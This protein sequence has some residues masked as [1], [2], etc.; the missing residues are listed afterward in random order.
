[1]AS[2][3]VSIFGGSGFLGRQIVKSLAV[4][5]V[6]IRVAVR[7]PERAS[8][9]KRMGR[10]GQIGLV[11]A[12]VWEE[13]SVARAV[14][15]STWVINTVGHYVEKSGATFDAIHG[16]GAHNVARQA[17]N[18]GV[19]R[20]IHI[21]GVGADPE[22]GSTYVRARGLGEDLVKG[23]F[24]DVTILRPSVLFGPDDSFFNTLAGL[25]RQTP[26]LP[27]FGMGRT[28]LQP[29]FVG[30]VSE[31]CVNVLADPST[32]GKVYEL[33]GPGIYTYKALV[34]LVLEHVGKRRALVPVPFFVWDALAALLSVLANPPVTRDQVKLMKS[35]NVV[36]EAALTLED[37]GIDPT[38]VE[39]VLPTYIDGS[40]TTTA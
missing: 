9:L 27:L 39:E 30:D 25:A 15:K 38:P 28:K 36:G 8:F 35:D 11:R 12:N 37:L 17:R 14:K 16:Q 20:L 24:E 23:A 1:M 29:V 22:S 21:S 3:R 4:E 7:H 5:G 34:N 13:P 32:Q 2:K 31:A 19:E 10:D 26:A 40:A 33:G 18:A 6:S